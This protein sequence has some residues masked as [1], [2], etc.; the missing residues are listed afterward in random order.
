MPAPARPRAA[1]V[2]PTASATRRVAAVVAV[3]ATV[4]VGAVVTASRS[5]AVPGTPTTTLFEESFAGATTSSPSWSRPSA[6]SNTACLTGSEDGAQSPI[7]GCGGD[8]PGSG[9]LR[10][11]SNDIAQVG[12]VF[13]D[14]SLPSARGIDVSFDSYQWAGSS[15]PAD[16][17]SFALAAADPA[18]PAAPAH[19]GPTGG[20]LGYYG[21][22]GVDGLPHGYSGWAWTSTGGSP[23]ATPPATASARGTPRCRRPSRSAGRVTA[24]AATASSARS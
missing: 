23:T 14:A 15:P 22:P 24:P 1:R 12:T 5:D 16:G 18:A 6:A 4:A 3:V 10:L 9:V 13:Y 19:A 2:V 8:A 7:P 17:M 20:A 11:S 21:I